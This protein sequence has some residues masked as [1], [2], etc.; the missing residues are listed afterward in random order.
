MIGRR[1][2]CLIAAGFS[3][4]AFAT[5]GAQTPLGTGAV[6]GIAVDS[7]GKTISGVE[8]ELTDLGLRSRTSKSG[9]YRFDSVQAGTHTLKA[10]K[11]GTR[12]VTVIFQVLRDDVTSVDVVMK[13]VATAAV[14]ALAPVTVSAESR[15]S[16]DAPPGFLQ[17]LE[18]G[19]G[20][21]FTAA[22]IKKIRPG[23]VS[24]L[25]RRVPGLKVFPNGEIFSN[26][27]IVS[28][29]T[30]S[31]AYGMPIY[32][33]NVQ[34]GGGAMGD[35]ETLTDRSL[36]RKPDFMS[37]TSA[38]RSPIDALKPSQIV[39][40]EIYNGPATAPATITGTTSS[41]G[42]ILMWTK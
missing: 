31:C 19:Q 9:I 24:E 16:R 41:C 4:A 27:G 26:R 33:D 12:G 36:E 22:D 14:T 35:P 42:V 38:G 40:I 3:V 30:E 39:G 18:S 11:L 34:V 10:R 17:R 29:N 5:G 1:L 15:G 32:V 23:K 6:Q 8:I 20:T 7:S 21:Y 37:P 28:L 2:S 13:P 25:M